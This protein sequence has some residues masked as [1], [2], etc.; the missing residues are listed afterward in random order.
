M[1]NGVDT[2]YDLYFDEYTGKKSL[3]W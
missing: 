3:D 1:I 2:D